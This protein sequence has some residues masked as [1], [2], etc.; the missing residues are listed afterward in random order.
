LLKILPGFQPLV[1]KS[2]KIKGGGS[3]GFLV[4]AGLN[5][6]LETGLFLEGEFESISISLY[7]QGKDT[8]IT[9][10]YVPPG[11]SNENFLTYAKTL[12]FNESK[13]NILLGDFNIDLAKPVNAEIK[14]HFSFIGMGPLID[15]PTRVTANSANIIDHIYSNNCKVSGFILETDT[16]DHFTVGLVTDSRGTCGN[17]NRQ[18]RA[19]ARP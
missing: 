18:A 5:Y 4:R 10:L 11:C 8:V 12:S 17:R 7:F 15:R 6:K 9:N 14:M 3:V 13:F 1:A 2:R 16:T 19:L